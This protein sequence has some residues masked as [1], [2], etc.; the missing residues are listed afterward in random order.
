VD[1]ALEAESGHGSNSF[2]RDAPGLR[3]S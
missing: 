1:E 3:G 2:V